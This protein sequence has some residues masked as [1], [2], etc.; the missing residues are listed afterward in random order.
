MQVRLKREKKYAKLR[1]L[2]YELGIHQS[3]IYQLLDRSQTWLSNRFNGS[4]CFT[5]DE[6]YRILD[7]LNIPHSEF[8]KFFPPFGHY[9]EKDLK[10]AFSIYG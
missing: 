6:G 1:G 4:E 3:E 10:E 5:I 2:M 9:T 8:T 7:F